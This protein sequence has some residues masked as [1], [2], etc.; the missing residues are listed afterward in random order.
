[1]TPPTRVLPP[2]DVDVANSDNRSPDPQIPNLSVGGIITLGTEGGELHT[3]NTAPQANTR[4]GGPHP[5][6]IEA[7]RTNRGDLHPHPHR[8]LTAHA[9]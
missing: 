3:N 1:M 4:K 9:E 7:Q 2:W 5:P 6:V 8:T